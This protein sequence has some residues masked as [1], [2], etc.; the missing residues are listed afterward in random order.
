MKLIDDS[1][2]ARRCRFEQAETARSAVRRA[3]LRAPFFFYVYSSPLSRVF[4]R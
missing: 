4:D 2:E 3:A 1:P